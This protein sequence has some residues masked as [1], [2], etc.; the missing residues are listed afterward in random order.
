MHGAPPMFHGDSRL[1][2]AVDLTRDRPSQLHVTF[3]ELDQLAASFGVLRASTAD[4]FRFEEPGETHRTRKNM[5]LYTAVSVATPCYVSN[6]VV[7]RADGV[8]TNVSCGFS[9]AGRR[10]SDPGGLPTEE[11]E[12]KTHP[13][14]NR[15]QA[16]E[17]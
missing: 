13:L 9:D 10:H 2:W 1:F 8:D 11:Q 14:E 16:A 17:A 15:A 4:L 7:L 6:G 3:P 5:N 12:K